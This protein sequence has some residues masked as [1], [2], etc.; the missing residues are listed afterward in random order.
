MASV[1]V[2]KIGRMAVVECEGRIVQSDSAFK[3]RDAVISQREARIIVLDL[4]ELQTI[5]GGGL[6]ML[7]FLQRWTHDHDIR[8]KLFNPNLAVQSKLESMGLT[9]EFDIATMDEM[10]R[11]LGQEDTRY[12]TAA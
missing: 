5:E 4:S 10:I 11:L 6:G 1:H 9:T 7:Q 2:E 12:S 8:F 3:L